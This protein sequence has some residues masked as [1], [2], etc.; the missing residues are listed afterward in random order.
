MPVLELE[1]RRIDGKLILGMGRYEGRICV[2]SPPS[3]FFN[4]SRHLCK[5]MY[6]YV[7]IY[8]RVVDKR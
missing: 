7:Y 3:H 2:D 8:I 4:T 6:I 1:R 5:P